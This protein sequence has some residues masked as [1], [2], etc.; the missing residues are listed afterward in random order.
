MT[1]PTKGIDDIVH[2]PARM[3]RQSDQTMFSCSAGVPAYYMSPATKG[4]AEA[5]FLGEV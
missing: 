5:T 2:L 4:E 3:T 1:R